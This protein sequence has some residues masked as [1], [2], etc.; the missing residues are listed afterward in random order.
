MT[1]TNGTVAMTTRVAIFNDHHLIVEGLAAV[2]AHYPQIELRQIGLRAQRL[3]QAVDVVLYDI[4]AIDRRQITIPAALSPK[5]PGVKVVM[6]G[7]QVDAT[8][9]ESGLEHGFDG[10]LD[11]SLSAAAIVQGIVRVTEGE[12]VIE[13]GAVRRTQ[14]VRGDWPGRHEG[15]TLRESEVMVM[16]TQGRSNQQI[17]EELF[18]SVNT[19][20][21]YIR[22][23]YKKMGVSRRGEAVAWGVAHELAILDTPRT[24]R[25]VYP[26]GAQATV[27]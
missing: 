4:F 20:K 14:D 17:A 25:I 19:I 12:R 16:V 3:E 24:Y 7:W 6:F 26:D 10:Y 2:L 22:K 5:P 27:P 23:A 15:L 1:H 13:L 9:I 18:L 11:K 8:L 21:T